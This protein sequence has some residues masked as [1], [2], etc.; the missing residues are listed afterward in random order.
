MNLTPDQLLSHKEDIASVIRALKEKDPSRA[1][2]GGSRLVE[3]LVKLD[4]DEAG[5][6]NLLSGIDD[7]VLREHMDLLRKYISNVPVSAL[8]HVSQ[9]GHSVT[10][11]NLPST[12]LTINLSFQTRTAN[13]SLDSSQDLEDTL[14]IGM[15]VVEAVSETMQLMKDALAPLAQRNCIGDKFKEN[16][17]RA[18]SAVRQIRECYNT[19]V[20]DESD[21]TS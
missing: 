18:E 5:W 20:T 10:I 1:S 8:S 9:V 4:L 19:I 13:K 17:E 12:S 16:L 21:N 6:E 2:K 3:D 14:W 7:A 15:A 11:S